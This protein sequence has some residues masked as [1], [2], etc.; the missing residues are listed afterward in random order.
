MADEQILARDQIPGQPLDQTVLRGA[1]KI[2]HHIP[3]EDHVELVFKWKGG[4]HEV[5]SFE[6]DHRLEFGDQPFS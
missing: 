4:I 5:Q 3:A 1:V 2:D 6:Q